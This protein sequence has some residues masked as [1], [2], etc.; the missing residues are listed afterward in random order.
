MITVKL[1]YTNYFT[2]KGSCLKDGTVRDSS[3][4]LHSSGWAIAIHTNDFYDVK[5][6]LH[7]NAVFPAIREMLE[8]FHEEEELDE[9]GLNEYMNLLGTDT[10]KRTVNHNSHGE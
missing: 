10:G 5:E 4:T 3:I 6:G 9:A 2:L 7:R 8:N 1:H